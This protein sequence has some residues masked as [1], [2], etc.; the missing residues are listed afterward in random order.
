MIDIFKRGFDPHNETAQTIFE[1][2]K[3]TDEERQIAKTLN[4]GTIYGGGA[5]MVMSQLPNLTEKDAQEFL[6]R[7]YRSYPGLKSWQQKVTHGAPTLTEGEG[8]ATRSPDRPS[9]G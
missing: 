2:S 3:I 4:Y 1:R 6:N 7:F 5:N 8:G 9:D